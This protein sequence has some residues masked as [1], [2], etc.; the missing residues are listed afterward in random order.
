MSWGYP[1]QK[2]L[3]I[4]VFGAWGFPMQKSL[5]FSRFW[6]FL[7]KNAWESTGSWVFFAQESLVHVNMWDTG[8]IGQMPL[9]DAGLIPERTQNVRYSAAMV[10]SFIPRFCHVMETCECRSRA[11]SPVRLKRCSKGNDDMHRFLSEG[12]STPLAGSVGVALEQGRE[13]YLSE[14]KKGGF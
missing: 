10:A 14:T 11:Q 13:S 12:H 4:S 3:G 8:R 7:C 2:I 9:Q 6:A 1:T 5:E